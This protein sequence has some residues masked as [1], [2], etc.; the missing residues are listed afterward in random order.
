MKYV[1]TNLNEVIKVEGIYTIHYYEYAN[2]FSYSGEFH[3][4]WEIVYAD[5]KNVVITAGNQEMTLEAGQMYIHK[6]N[7]F[8]KIRCDGVRAAN[9]VIL[10]FDCDCTELLSIAGRII[11]CNAEERRIMGM[12]IK[13]AMDAF[14]TPLGASYIREMEK[15]NTGQF[16]CEQMIKLYME[17][18]LILLMRGNHHTMPIKNKENVPILMEICKY[19][20]QNVN[21]NLRFSDIQKEFNLSAS[22]VKRLFHNHMNC[23]AMEHF[24]KL[25]IDKAKE[26]IRE[27]NMNFTEISSALGFNSPQYFT[28]AFQRVSGMTP[29]EYAHS[30]K[31]S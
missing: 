9:S 6:P 17:Q 1:R 11:N 4:F 16:G 13:E 8:H 15:S 3:D 10:S 21:Q 29:S 7:E 30:V 28:T 14:S 26:M 23:G 25:K 24:L 12:I 19:L 5:K 27:N 2:D 20:E 22:V 18:L 31:R